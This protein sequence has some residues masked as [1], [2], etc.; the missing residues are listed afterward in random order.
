MEPIALT[1]RRYDGPTWLVAAAIYGIWFLLVWYHALLP[2]WLILP[3]G[4][5]LVAWQFSLQHEAIHAFRGVP[6]WLR[7]ALVFPPLGLWFPYPLYRK[8]HSTHHRDVNLTLPGVDPE[9]YYVKRADWQR[10]GRLHRTLLIVNQTLA[11]RMIIGPPLRLW[12]LLAREARRLRERDF[13]HLPHWAVHGVALAVLFWFVSGICGFPAWQYCLLVAYPGMSLGL[14]RAF[15]EH[16]A[17]PNPTERIASV[18]SNLVFGLLFLNNNLHVAHHLYPTMP[19]YDIPRYYR[20]NKTRLLEE[21]GHFIYRGYF[22]LVVRYLLRPV[23][24]PVHPTH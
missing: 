8:S 15:I 4:A 3:V 13:S 21:N 16:R 11:G 2:W 5:Y 1:F 7:F 9:S 18:E 10:M 22:E 17:A 6:A 12:G 23:F 24:I 14:L 19:W 20:E